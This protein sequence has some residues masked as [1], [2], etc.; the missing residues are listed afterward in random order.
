MK[1]FTKSYLL[2]VALMLS[3][4]SGISTSADIE[5]NY[6]VSNIDSISSG[7]HVINDYRIQQLA[8][9]MTPFIKSLSDNSVESE[10][11]STLSS[12]G[13]APPLTYLEVHA[14]IS[15]QHPSL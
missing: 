11:K 7:L 3:F 9:Q 10:N 12:R 8:E 2:L 4:F 1:I 13:S 15:S 6:Q 5:S 14:V